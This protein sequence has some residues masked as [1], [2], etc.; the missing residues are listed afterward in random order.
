MI[1][2]RIAAD[3]VAEYATLLELSGASPFRVRAYANAVRALE[4]LTSSLDELLAAGTLT[5]VKG[6]GDSVA[7]LVA[8]LADTGTAQAYEKLRAATPDGL[9]DML[10]VPGLGPRKIVA[11]RKAL[12]IETLD[13]LEQACRTGQLAALKG[14]GSKTQATILK[15]VEFIRA[16]EG[17]CRVDS[18][19][20]SA[21]S[22]LTTLCSHAQH[23]AIAGDLR[24]ARETV[25]QLDF[26]ISSTDAE[27]AT[28]AFVTH[29][30]IAEVLAP[31]TGRLSNGLQANLH[32]VS[33][34]AF[35][36]ALH[37]YTGSEEHRAALCAKATERGL[38]LD[39]RG[40]WRGDE[41][42]ECAD[43]AA[44]F[45]ALG[46]A[47]IPPELRE[48]QGEVEAAAADALPEL[49]T[50]ADIR[51]MLHVHST[52][53]DG[54]DSLEAM[55]RAVQE[56]GFE[57]IGIADHSQAAA[58]AGGLRVEDVQRQWEE[59]DRLNEEL[60][61]FRI[62]KGIESDILSDGSL[63]YDDNLLAQFDFVVASV[64][65]QFNLSRD[66]MTARIVRAI[67]HPAATIVGHPTG[68]L[69]LDREGYA[70]DIDSI[71][72]A[73]AR[74]GVALEINAHPSRLDLDWRHVKKARDHGVQIAVNTDAHSVGGLDHLDYGIGI[75]RK[76]WLCAADIPNAL[77]REAIA[78]WFQS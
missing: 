61:P 65:S 18:A 45:A 5:E 26:V 2:A 76:G 73:A 23:F 57:Y 60:A 24:R 12:G 44:L 39:E 7:E 78:A 20:Q 34:D 55:A 63:D 8:E 51:G 41:R 37:Y 32:M 67:E 17:H 43:E 47:Y 6:I 50:T 27:A 19:H 75:A 15:G 42:I 38:V 22:L 58:Y 30:D 49:V 11:I 36:A 31:G 48:N 9:L 25:H 1:T 53:S 52:Y 70:V 46:L 72:E 64:H 66:A 21:Q 10:R 16:H 69:L 56:R 14:F 28:A 68:R 40:L 77:S 4:T 35:P 13:A 74:C 59:I 54:A 29:P 62:F 33:D 71:I 3:F